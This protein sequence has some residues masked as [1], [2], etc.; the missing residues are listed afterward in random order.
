MLITTLIQTPHPSVVASLP[1][2]HA[3]NYKFQHVSSDLSQY[4]LSVHYMGIVLITYTHRYI[5]FRYSRIFHP[6]T[7]NIYSDL[8]MEC[9]RSVPEIQ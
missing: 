7:Q 9:I 8:W 5:V 1:Y 6:N 3:Y 2:T 4:R